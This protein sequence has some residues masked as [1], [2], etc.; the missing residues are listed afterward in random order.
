MYWLIIIANIE[1]TLLNKYALIFVLENYI[2]YSGMNNS[3]SKMYT[4]I[5]FKYD[6]IC[7][8]YPLLKMVGWCLARGAV[9]FFLHN[10]L[11]YYYSTMLQQNI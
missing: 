8:N 3:T 9:E 10:N 11:Y 5:F 2:F 4:D 6:C 1:R 7:G